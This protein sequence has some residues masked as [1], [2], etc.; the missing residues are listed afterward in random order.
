[1]RVGGDIRLENIEVVEVVVIRDKNPWFEICM[2]NKDHPYHNKECDKGCPSYN[3]CSLG[4]YIEWN[5]YLIVDADTEEELN[6]LA[7]ELKE[8]GFK[9]RIKEE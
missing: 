7:E 6:K 4:E 3:I 9:V 8:R 5:K 2:Q 1:L